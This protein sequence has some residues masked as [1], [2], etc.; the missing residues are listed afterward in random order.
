MTNISPSLRLSAA[1]ASSTHL[2]PQ[3]QQP[4]QTSLDS[5]RA[6]HRRGANSRS[7]N[8]DAAI[9]DGCRPAWRSSA[10]LAYA[11]RKREGWA[12]ELIDADLGRRLLFAAATLALT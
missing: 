1:R 7:G 3:T 6:C 9:D 4:L 2:L 8:G 12:E 10:R 11:S 5:E